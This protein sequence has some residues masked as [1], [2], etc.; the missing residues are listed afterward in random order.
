MKLAKILMTTTVLGAAAA[1]SAPASA[2]KLSGNDAVVAKASEASLGNYLGKTSSSALAQSVF[3]RLTTVDAS[4]VPAL[5]N[6]KD[7][8]R[9]WHTV[10]LDTNAIDHTPD[11]DTGVAPRQQLGPHRAARAF[12]MVEIAVFDA[13]NSFGKPF[14]PY[15]NI[16]NTNNASREAAVSYAAHTVLRA[17]YPAQ[18]ARLD[19]LLAGDVAQITDSQARINR[20]RT[21]GL[22]AA[23][24]I[25]AARATDNSGDPEPVFGGGGRVASGTVGA[26]GGPVNNG[27]LNTFEWQPDPND[28]GTVALGAFW[29][30][31]TPF[32]LNDG[33]QFRAPPPPTPGSARYNSAHAEVATIGG[34][35]GASGID[36]GNNEILSTATPATRFIGNFWGYDAVPLLGVPPRLYAQISS[37]VGVAQGGM[38]AV[39]LARYLAMIQVVMADSG[40][41]A[42]DSKY[43]YNY[44]RPVTGIRRDDGVAATQSETDW[45]PVGASVINTT[46]P[47]RATPPFP[48]YPS[49]HATF[50]GSIFAVMEQVFGDDVG[51]TFVSDEYNGLGADPFTPGTPRPLVPVRFQNFDEAAAENGVSRVFNGVHWNYDDSEGQRIGRRIARH[52][53]NNVTAFQ[54]N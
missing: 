37:Q 24:A 54:P 21:A 36:S 46:N 50:G 9:F 29:G 12:A 18:G 20:G 11:P 27:S 1:L 14:K 22:A 3:D 2:Q 43:Y 15:N 52:L 38:N 40:I 30:G 33:D 45:N 47:I 8:V 31:V 13:L 41:A 6:A 7:R 5:G 53:K 17:L 19:A 34:S 32:I 26:D 48:A 28:V 25:L 51:F 44:W 39:E 10:L 49:G 4:S 42:W 16:G 35:P 23:N